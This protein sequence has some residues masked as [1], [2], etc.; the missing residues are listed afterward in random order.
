MASRSNLT[1]TVE[2]DRET[3]KRDMDLIRMLLL[4]QE[5]GER[6]PGLDE[7]P[8]KVQAHHAAL[9]IDAGLIEGVTQK[10]RTGQVARFHILRLTWA[11]HD[12]LDAARSDTVWNKAKEKVFKPG[13]SWTFSALLEFLKAEVRA[14]MLKHGIL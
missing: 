12:F 9:L 6:M 10:D 5:G 1:P 4:Q 11:G 3:M 7:Y 2:N 8:A 14:E 13:L